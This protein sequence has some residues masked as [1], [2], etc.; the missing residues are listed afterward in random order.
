MRIT[1]DRISLDPA[2]IAQF[3]PAAQKALSLPE[4]WRQ[5]GVSSRTLKEVAE[6]QFN[7]AVASALEIWRGSVS[8]GLKPLV[9]ALEVEPNSSKKAQVEALIEQAKEILD[10]KEEEKEMAVGLNPTDEPAVPK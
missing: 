3:S 7:Q 10:V 4:S 5:P 8:E 6:E 2:E 9:E 1:N